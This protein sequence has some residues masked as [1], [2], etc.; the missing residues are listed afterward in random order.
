METPIVNNIKGVIFDVGG[1]LISSPVVHI[2]EYE[3]ELNLP[4]GALTLAFIYGSPNNAFCR[5]ERGEIKLRQFCREFEAECQELIK[6]R[7]DRD[8]PGEFSAAELFRRFTGNRT[9]VNQEMIKLLKSIKTSGLKVGVVTNNWIDDINPDP[10]HPLLREISPFVDATIQ[11]CR[12]GIRK[13]DKDI[14]LLACRELGLKPNEVVF[15]DDLGMNLKTARELG[16]RMI[17]VKDIPAAVAQLKKTL[18]NETS[19]NTTSKL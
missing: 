7:L 10:D 15:L 2:Q 19:K 3:S 12:V 4:K 5:L 13:P 18:Q 11:S 14:Y 1:V 9:K 6:S 8:L 17:L 16:M